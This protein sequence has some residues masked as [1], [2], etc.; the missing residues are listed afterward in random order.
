MPYI[1]KTPEIG[2]IGILTNS[3]TTSKRVAEKFKFQ[4]CATK[5]IDIFDSQ[6]NTVFVATRHDSHG[7]F[8]LKCL[9]ANKNVFVEKPICLLESDLKEII[10]EQKKTKKTVMIGFN[11]RFSPLTVKLKKAM[12]NNPM[13][14]LYRV[15]AGSIPKDHWIQDPEIGGGRIIGEVCHF[16]DYLTFINGSTPI[17]ISASAIPDTNNLND[18]LNI[19]VQF[20]NGS[21]GIIAYYANGSKSMDKEYIEVFSSGKSAILN[22]F[23]ELKIYS[24][25]GFKRTK[26]FNQNKGQ[27]EMVKAYFNGLLGKEEEPPIPFEEVVTVTKA[28]FRVIE[29]IKYGGKQIKI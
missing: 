2:L 22:D 17:K 13:T 23:K 5:E 28:S 8:V 16:I 15:N 14:M 12:G 20:K 1:P 19:L 3:G 26:L 27:K 4:F 9:K 21:S 25:G 10:E 6:T 24:K 7:S 18:T 11:R 29:S